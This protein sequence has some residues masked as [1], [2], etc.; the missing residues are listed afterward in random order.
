MAMSR[1]CGRSTFNWVLCVS[2]T[3]TAAAKQDCA[4]AAA[5]DPGRP[6]VS[7]RVTFRHDQDALAGT[8]YRPSGRGPH[9]GIVLIT[10]SGDNDRNYHGVG[11]ALGKHFATLGFFCLTWDKPGVGESIGDFNLQTFHD[12]ATEAL[13]AIRFLQRRD[14]VDGRWVGVW[15]HSQGGMVAPLAASL[16]N[17]VAFLIVAAGW[18]GPAWQQ[19]AVRVEQELRADGFTEAQFAEAVRFTRRRMELIRGTAPFEELDREQEAVESAPWFK[20]VHRC[21]RV[22][23]ESARK[24][25][26]FDNSAS[27]EKVKCPVLAIYCGKDVSSGPP[28]PLLAIIRRGL[29]KAANEDVTIKLFPDAD[30]DL[31]RPRPEGR[32]RAESRTPAD[33]PDFVPGYLE[34]MSAWLAAHCQRRVD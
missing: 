18:Q 16:S 6:I 20:S 31:C 1:Y 27:W 10:G 4:L 11:P 33:S 32:Q 9:P 5:P 30:H 23:F 12:R 3:A 8:L 14:G 28:E 2:L 34:A 7:E 17:D 21:D 26:N 24:V 19:D 15:G 22:L 29:K 25:V 13:A